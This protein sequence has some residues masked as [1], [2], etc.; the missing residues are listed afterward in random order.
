LKLSSTNG[1]IVA[2]TGAAGYLGSRLLAYLTTQPWVAQIIALDQ[3]PLANNSSGRIHAYQ[4]DVS[5]AEALAAIFARHSVT[6]LV[7]AAFLLV[8][9]PDMSESAMRAANVDGSRCVIETALRHGVQQI[10]FVSSVAIYG[11]LPGH[12]ARVRED[13]LLRPTMIYGKHKA[14]VETILHELGSAYPAARIAIPRLAAVVGAA[15][16]D[17][18]H[19]R[20]LTA[21]PV[22]VVANGGRALTQAIHEDDAAELIGTLLEQDASGIFNG[23]ADDS[24]AWAAIGGLSSRPIVS[25]PRAVLNQMTRLSLNTTLPALNGFTRE[26]VDLFAE[27]LVVDNSAARTQ[28]AWTPRYSTLAAF[29][30]MFAALGTA[31]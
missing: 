17:Y 19:L 22:F 9:P 8:Q 13:A 28:L 11:Y 6:H 30:Q 26:I 23:A 24:A 31:R 5:D 2:V 7:H 15:G 16:R 3:K 12:P 10:V 29:Q 27:S 21:Q 25:M 4:V 14:A 20:A 1:K 18:S